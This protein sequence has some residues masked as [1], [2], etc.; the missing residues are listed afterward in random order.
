M[1]IDTS[2]QGPKVLV[3]HTHSQEEFADSTP[4]DPSTS[5][6]GIGEY[7]VQLLNAKGI[8]TIHD[9]GVYDIING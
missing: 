8:N 5:I 1:K 2:T 6:I 9:T 3:F 7:L 4:G